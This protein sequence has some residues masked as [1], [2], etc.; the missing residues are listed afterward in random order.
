MGQRLSIVLSNLGQ[1]LLKFIRPGNMLILCY[2]RWQWFAVDAYL[3]GS[4]WLL[5]DFNMR[6][7]GVC[8]NW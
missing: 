5:A 7:F 2:I 6:E 8:Q 3:I 1:N 4:K